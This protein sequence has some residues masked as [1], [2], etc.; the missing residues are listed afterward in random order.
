MHEKLYWLGFSVFPGIGPKRFQVLLERFG[1]AE[2]AWKEDVRH[3][4]NILGKVLGEKFALFRK[5]FGLERYAES[6]IEKNIQIVT[7]MDEEYPEL[8]K[9]TAAQA[10]FKH[11]DF[12][13]P[14]SKYTH[15]Y[16][17][18]P[19]LLYIKGNVSLFNSK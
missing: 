8:L 6:L 3:L 19:F 15:N 13:S 16:N 18:I 12:A 11:E 10:Q 5:S 17:T 4:E 1:S 2:N 7:L 9:Q 14:L